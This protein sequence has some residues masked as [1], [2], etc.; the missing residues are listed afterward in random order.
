MSKLI[1]KILIE[2]EISNERL[3]DLKQFVDGFTIIVNEYQNKGI[4]I[5]IRLKQYHSVELN[6][7]RVPKEFRGK[8]LASEFLNKLTSLA[9]KYKIIITL[10]PSASFGANVN[11]LKIFYKRFGFRMNTGNKADHRFSDSMIRE[12]K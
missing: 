12:P 6:L 3:P 10:S 5:D 8:G 9:D 11:K 1:D 2:A 4:E 7:I